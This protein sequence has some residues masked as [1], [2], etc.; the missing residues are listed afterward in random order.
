MWQEDYGH[1]SDT[2]HYPTHSQC[3]MRFLGMKFISKLNISTGSWF[4]LLFSLVK[5]AVHRNLSS[6]G[7]LITIITEM[8]WGWHHIS[9][10]YIVI[11][12]AYRVELTYINDFEWTFSAIQ[13]KTDFNVRR[14]WDAIGQRPLK[15][16]ENGL[17][18][19]NSN[20][21]RITWPILTWQI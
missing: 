7:N 21:I 12:T 3:E 11:T 19:S 1:S 9:A 14:K 20:V 17:L 10:C 2:I 6:K 4:N 5:G 18:R 16:W 8:G 13:A 15:K